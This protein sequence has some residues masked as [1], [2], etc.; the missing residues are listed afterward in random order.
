LQRIERDDRRVI[1]IIAAFLVARLAFAYALGPGID[2]SYT[3]AIAR[4]L[5]LSYFDHPPL[6]QWIV[7]FAARALGEG[8][9]ARLPFIALFAAT[10]W[11]LYRLTLDLFGARAGVIAVFALNVTPFFFASAGTWIVPD[12]PL[13]FGLAAAAWALE[14]LF[15]AKHAGRSAIWLLWLAAGA[16]LGVAGL[17]KYSAALSVA[18]LA[19][20]GI[21]APGRRRWLSDPGLYVAAALALAM[22]TPVFVWNAEHGW[23]SFAFQGAR[24][25]LGLGLKPTQFLVMALG[26]IAYLLPWIFAILVL[27]LAEAWR[28]R[29]D[30]RKFF[31]FCLALPPIVL[32]TLTPLWGARGLPQWTMPGWFFAYPLLGAWLDERAK[33][34]IALRWS[35]LVSCGTL[36]AVAVIFALQAATGFPLRLLPPKAVVADPTLEAFAWRDLRSAPL[37][38]PPPAFVLSTHWSDAGKI[39]LALG[40]KVPV[41]VISDDPRGWAYVA[42]G[43]R[44]LGRDGVLVARPAEIPLARAAAALSFKEIG[45]TRFCTLTRN[46]ASAVE[47][48]LVPVR[49]LTRRLPLPYPGAPGG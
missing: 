30:E 20:F 19:A 16:G 2:E 42:E 49:G 31:L 43:G 5:N 40:P 29:Q 7:H 12:G 35:A 25:S 39:A 4:T 34:D 9:G 23:A 1:A 8:F 47:L 48:A 15:F 6:H 17:S 13:L 38:T 32:F 45:D 28:E 3:L 11:I 14:R 33:S 26:E 37:L 24:G 27:G 44:L 18:G 21:L 22:A 41:F 36:A 10:G 46:G